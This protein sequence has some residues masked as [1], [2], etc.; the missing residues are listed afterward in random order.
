MARHVWLTKKFSKESIDTGME[1]AVYAHSKGV[2]F[3]VLCQLVIYYLERCRQ[4]G[5]GG[6]EATHFVQRMIDT[7]HRYSKGV[8]AK[9]YLEA[10]MRLIQAYAESAGLTDD[11]PANAVF[12]KVIEEELV[13]ILKERKRYY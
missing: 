12:E 9:H 2:S 11:A 8:N 5:R 4:N 1:V 7:G 6:M 13:P 10:G 3:T